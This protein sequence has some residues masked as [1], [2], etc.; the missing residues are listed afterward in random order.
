VSTDNVSHAVARYGSTE[1]WIDATRKDLW[2]P[3]GALRWDT[4]ERSM[5]ETE[6]IFDLTF[7][8]AT[9]R[10]IGVMEVRIKKDTL[11]N[12]RIGYIGE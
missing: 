8:N 11:G 6:A 4:R 3:W 1:K 5:S 9:N 7:F 10:P 2:I 12:W